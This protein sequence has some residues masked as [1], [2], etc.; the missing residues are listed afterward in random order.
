MK[1]DY[2]QKPLNIF[3]RY[4]AGHKKLFALDMR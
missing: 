3:M 1:K 2:T 4:I